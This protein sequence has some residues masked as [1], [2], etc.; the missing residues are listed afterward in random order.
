MQRST[1]PTRSAVTGRRATGSEVGQ[2][3]TAAGELPCGHARWEETEHYIAAREWWDQRRD[4][5]LTAEQLA[6]VRLFGKLA[7]RPPP[8]PPDECP[9]EQS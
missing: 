2:P 5:P 9:N 8:E 7:A 3:R 6:A 1:I 4:E